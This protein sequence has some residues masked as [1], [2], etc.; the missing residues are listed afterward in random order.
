MHIFSTLTH[1]I[2][3]A[4]RSNDMIGIGNVLMVLLIITVDDI[5]GIEWGSRNSFPYSLKSDKLC[6]NVHDIRSD[7]VYCWDAIVCILCRGNHMTTKL[8]NIE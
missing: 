5:H 3:F 7:W 6:I 1:R 2:C 4:S 8:A